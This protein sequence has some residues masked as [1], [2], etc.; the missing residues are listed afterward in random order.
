MIYDAG[1]MIVTVITA[2]IG[3]LVGM[4]LRQKIKKY[5]NIRLSAG[6]T[7]AQVAKQMLEHYHLYDVNIVEGRG[8]LTDHYN[9]S[10]KTVSLSPAIYH[11]QSISAA[12]VAAHECGHAVQHDEAYEWLEARS[13]I[14]PIVQFSAQIQ[15]YVLIGAF[16]TFGATSG[17]SGLGNLLMLVCIALFAVTALFSFIT[18]PV[19]FDASK[20]ALAWLDETNITKGAEYD[21]AKD[22]LKWAAMTY[23]ASALSALIMVLY[24]IMKFRGNQR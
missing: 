20:R 8:T 21:G 14:V 22:A 17:A 7:G 2:A 6:L 11:G 4:V 24:L 10:T 5:N 16:A 3:G 15:Q 19:E 18:L 23:V 9:P 1:F 13:R 12:A